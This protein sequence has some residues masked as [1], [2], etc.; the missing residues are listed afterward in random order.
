MAAPA[1]CC[2]HTTAA[3]ASPWPRPA[4]LAARL[5]QMPA[6]AGAV[7]ALGSN[8]ILQK[9]FD[10]WKK[11]NLHFKFHDF[12]LL[13]MLSPLLQ[14]PVWKRRFPPAPL[15]ARPRPVPVPPSPLPCLCHPGGSS[16]VAA[17]PVGCSPPAWCWGQDT[18]AFIPGSS[19]AREAAKR[20]CP[21]LLRA[22]DART[23]RL[24]RP[25]GCVKVRPQWVL[26]VVKAA[27]WGILQTGK[28]GQRSGSDPRSMYDNS[29][30]SRRSHSQAVLGAGGRVS[31][32]PSLQSSPP[33]RP[34]PWD[35]GKG[36]PG[37]WRARRLVPQ[38]PEHPCGCWEPGA[39]RLALSRAAR[40][41][42]LPAQQHLLLLSFLFL[43][44]TTPQ[45]TAEG[46][47]YTRKP[48]CP[49][50]RRRPK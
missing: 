43:F 13:P 21:Q 20:S 2:L 5:E 37:T 49:E 15:L 33:P 45:V 36:T 8:F 7:T 31:L 24:L 27:L 41:K 32:L 26:V 29:Q 16:Q 6:R 1:A 10:T 47:L 38:G 4:G 12:L 28:R 44:N 42:G 25:H 40:G 17:M 11:A 18:H 39:L 30:V 19:T 3:P 48:L 50:L 35:R 34:K 23:V 14:A 46:M 9:C 22:G